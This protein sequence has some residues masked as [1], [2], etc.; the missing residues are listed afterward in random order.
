MKRL[1]RALRG[2]LCFVLGA[3]LALAASFDFW[4]KSVVDSSSRMNPPD[5]RIYGALGLV[6]AC[7]MLVIPAGVGILRL[8]DSDRFRKR[9]AIFAVL[10]ACWLLWWIGAQ[11]VPRPRAI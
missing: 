6:L 3:Y 4:G 2:V 9:H 5:R 7:L 8:M 11:F 1:I 10:I